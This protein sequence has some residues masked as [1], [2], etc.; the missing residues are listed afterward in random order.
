MIRKPIITVLGH[1][2]SGKTSFLDMIRGTK[3]VSQEAGAITQHIGATEVPIEIVKNLAGE[4]TKKYGFE[5]KIPG[6]L[7]IDTPGHEAFSNLRKR[8]GSIADLAVL[9]VDCIKGCEK[10]TLE[11]LDILKAFKVPFIIAMTKIDKMQGWDSK[12]LSF[13][14]NKE[15]Q[16]KELLEELDKKLYCIVGEAHKKGFLTE[17]FDRIQNFT[18]EI[19]IIPI[20][21]KT[22]EGFPEVLMFLAG[23]SQKYLEK[24][25]NIEVK[26]R[27]KGTILEVK[28]EKG[29]GKTIDVILYDGTIRTGDQI[30]LAG[31]QGIIET[32]IRALLLPKPLDEIS[33]PQER[34]DS[35]KEVHAASGLKIAAPGLE[36]ALAGSPLIVKA[37]KEEIEEIKKEIQS[38][39]I[40]SEENGVIIK[41]D[42][43]GSLEATIK[44]LQEKGIK[45]RKAN[46]GEITRRDVIEA[47]GVKEK[48]KI[49]GVILAF[50]TKI[51][52]EAI[53]EA[54]KN[55][56]K[57]FNEKIIYNLIEKYEKWVI[58]EKEKAKKDFL[59]EVVFPVKIK[60]M[61]E[62][63]FR[64]A[65]PVIIGAKI[66]EGKLKT[67]TKLMK[68][69]KIVGKVQGIQ[70]NGETIKN[71]SKGE[72]VAISISDA[73]LGR[74][75]ENNDELISFISEKDMEKL[76]NSQGILNEEEKELLKK[77]K[78]VKL[79]EE[80]K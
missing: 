35:V 58:E 51:N 23:L 46:V 14:E 53:E 71:A 37:T 48:D 3:I 42:T 25:L 34:F 45:V 4:L 43:L 62:N 66:L 78:E 50:N 6:L 59:A 52:P 67:G 54:K 11:S 5:L 65:K 68:N 8:G 1:V 29:L 10:Q 28:E 19:P 72:E 24:K 21:N 49:Q 30:V 31:K 77:I 2:D 69:G 16:S 73:V 26:G 15:N 70:N 13:T 74:G 22:G 36:N 63:V 60:L 55:E 79:Q 41:T 17:R 39:K 38:I 80:A 20:C 44:L 18:K 64:N 61:P 27:G 7:F 57:I 32:K 56:I 47:E 33:A 12:K 76:E 40:D 9:T 75:I